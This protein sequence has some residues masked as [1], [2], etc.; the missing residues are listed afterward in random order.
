MKVK[1]LIEEL[2]NYNQDL[3]IVIATMFTETGIE[4]IILTDRLV[5]HMNCVILKP[6]SELIA[7]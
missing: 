2:S 7:N 1:E 5:K 4:D 3:D 6:E